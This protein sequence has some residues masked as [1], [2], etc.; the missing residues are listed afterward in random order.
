MKETYASLP[1]HIYFTAAER[2]IW[3]RCNLGRV[4][5][6]PIGGQRI[7][8]TKS[9]DGNQ[10]G[11][12]YAEETFSPVMDEFE[13]LPSEYSRYNPSDDNFTKTDPKIVT[14]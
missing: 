11:S 1:P 3:R 10:T 13:G 6:Q 5:G 7:T 2:A 14:P 8:I 4:T 12:V 9:M